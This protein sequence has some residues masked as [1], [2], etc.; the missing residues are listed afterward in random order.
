MFRLMSRRAALAGMPRGAQGHPGFRC[1]PA[2]LIFILNQ[3]FGLGKWMGVKCR[4]AK[5]TCV[6]PKSSEN[7]VSV[8][9]TKGICGKYTRAMTVSGTVWGV[10]CGTRQYS[11]L[12][13]GK[14]KARV[15]PG[16]PWHNP[17]RESYQKS[18]WMRK[19]P[20]T[21]DCE[22]ALATAPPPLTYTKEPFGSMFW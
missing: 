18:R 22:L 15:S 11:E 10:F 16:L 12:V 4:A 3:S 8:T 6:A 13:D 19:R 21:A 9:G 2:K 14:K 5:L 1:R 17:R 20:S 7:M